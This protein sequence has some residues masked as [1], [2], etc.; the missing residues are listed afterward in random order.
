[1]KNIASKIN[2]RVFIASMIA[3]GLLTGLVTANIMVEDERECRTME[4][5]IRA[6]QNFDGTVSCSPPGSEDIDISEELEDRTEMKCL[7]RMT[8]HDSTRLWPIVT[9]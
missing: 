9:S 7:C 2:A 1:M 8:Y 3:L 5:D 4:D 6:E